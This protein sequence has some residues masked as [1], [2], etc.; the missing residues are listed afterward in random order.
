MKRN[1]LIIVGLAIASIL[2][3]IF[4]KKSIDQSYNSE[5]VIDTTKNIDPHMGH[6]EMQKNQET[7]PFYQGEVVSFEHGG[8]YT[9]IEVKEKTNLTFWIAVERAEVK[10]GDIIKFQKELVMHDF[11]SKWQM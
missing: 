8:G 11:K 4:A 9:Y 2:I 7:M 1:T 3:I 5:L 6:S 10:K